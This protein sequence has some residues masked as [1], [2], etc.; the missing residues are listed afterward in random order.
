MT[1]SFPIQIVFTNVSHSDAIED[2]I[3]HHANKLAHY[4]DQI[5][6]CHV[7]VGTNP[8]HN[9]GNIYHVYIELVIPNNTFVVNRDPPEDHAHEDVYVAIR[10]A[11]DAIKRQLLDS[12]EKH[13]S[14]IKHPNHN[15][16]SH[17]GKEG[18]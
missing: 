13:R 15:P 1:A 3:H 18:E 11:F 16:T 8:R 5:M 9:K 14:R 12:I 7:V 6:A 4:S 2:N 10:D 17:H